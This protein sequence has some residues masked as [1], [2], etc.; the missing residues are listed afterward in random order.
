MCQFE[1]PKIDRAIRVNVW[2]VNTEDSDPEQFESESIST[3]CQE[4][5]KAEEA[6]AIAE[7]GPIPT[8]VITWVIVVS[9]FIPIEF[10][11]PEASI[12][13][14][15]NV[16]VPSTKNP[17]KKVK[18]FYYSC[19]ICSYSSQNKTNMMTHTHHCLH[20]K[21]VCKIC[22]KEYESTEGM[23]NHITET[24]EGYNNPTI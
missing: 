12:P 7:H 4:A 8:D 5:A 24:H 23:E 18:C 13:E 22:K 6:S 20:I 16:K 14:T 3:L 19:Q 17:A 1:Y 15:E 11:I 9:T 21:L 10:G 2:E